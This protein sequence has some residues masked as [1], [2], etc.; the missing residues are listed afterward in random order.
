MLR[1][2]DDSLDQ[3]STGRCTSGLWSDRPSCHMARRFRQPG[4]EP[5]HPLRFTTVLDRRQ[6]A[7]WDDGR[8]LEPAI[9]RLW[10]GLS[11][12]DLKLSTFIAS[13]RAESMPAPPHTQGGHPDVPVATSTSEKISPLLGVG[14]AALELGAQHGGQGSHAAVECPDNVRITQLTVPG[15][16]RSSDG[17]AL[18][19]QSHN[20]WTRVAT[21]RAFCDNRSHNAEAH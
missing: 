13:E 16:G 4:T 7:Y 12:A 21:G 2:G 17:G 14:P 3:V 19:T 8:Q 18:P 11:S 9:Y 10:L 1:A 20:R 6:F 5:S 15:A